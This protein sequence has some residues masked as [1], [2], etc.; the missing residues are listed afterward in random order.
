M[1][2]TADEFTFFADFLRR[3]S[4]ISVGP[5]KRYLVESRLTPLALTL[6]YADSSALV[7]E[8]RRPLA[9]KS[10][11]NRAVEVMTTN[12]TS[13]F[14]DMRPFEVLRTT[15]VPEALRRNEATRQL[16]IWSAGA[17][18]GQELYSVAML[19]DQQFPQ[20]AGWTVT[21]YGTDLSEQV[22]AKARAARYSALEV[23]RGL[24]AA[25][26]VTYFSRDGNE[27]VLDHRIRARCQFEVMNLTSPWRV[28]PRFDIVF[29]RNVLIY[30]DV[31]AK[32]T[33]LERIRAHLSE[34]GVVLLGAAETTLGVVDDYV[35]VPMGGTV[36]YRV[37]QGEAQ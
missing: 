31:D 11:R 12:E 32:R 34:D 13:F 21:L 20:L 26:L 14:R 28:M 8:L 29:C 37:K 27:Y 10:L 33:V 6:G 30:F 2:L 4:A 35:A 24:P 25:L 9:D 1:A 17:S 23:N 19:L 22:L 36:V 16:R 7:N 18:T 3:E 5:D 15:L